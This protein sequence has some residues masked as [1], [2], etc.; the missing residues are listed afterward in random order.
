MVN[1]EQ[2]QACK[3]QLEKPIIDTILKETEQVTSNTKIFGI[4]KDHQRKGQCKK[5]KKVRE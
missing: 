1:K 4:K 3:L 2:E 5:K